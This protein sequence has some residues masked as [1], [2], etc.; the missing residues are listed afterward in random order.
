MEAQT[1]MSTSLAGLGDVDSS[2]EEMQASLDGNQ[3]PSGSLSRKREFG[4]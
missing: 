2:D 1:V 4:E 3:P